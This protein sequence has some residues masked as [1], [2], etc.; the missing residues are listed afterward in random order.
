M[1]ALLLAAAACAGSTASPDPSRDEFGVTEFKPLAAG[2]KKWVS[3]WGGNRTFKNDRDPVDPWFDV[4]AGTAGYR[5]HDGELL[6]SGSAPRMYV[7]DPEVKQQWRNVEITM[8]FK[9]VK[10]ADVPYAG[11]T[12]VARTNHGVTGDE[13]SDLC[14]TRGYGGRIRFDGATDFEK[15]TA[16]PRNEAQHRRVLWPHG[17]PRNK[18]MG[19]KFIVYDLP[20][21]DPKLELY[22]DENA[23][24]S[25]RM[26][27]AMIDTG[28][29][30][31]KVPC[32]K[33]INPRMKLTNSPNRKGSESGKPNIAVYFR[34]DGIAHDGLIYK[35]GSVRE[36]R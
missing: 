4:D 12:A 24:G 8:Y 25:W 9:R 2:G 34:S 22:L 20:N 18:W 36:I 14:D 11:M 10:D 30:F 26:V 21:G 19:Y 29:D 17:I 15:E 1:A 5:T 3:K 6:I 33:G 23:D 7:Y 32:A 31:G 16:H 27:N 13:T 35:N 28:R